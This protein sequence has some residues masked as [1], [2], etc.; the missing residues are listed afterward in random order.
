M[1]TRV[2]EQPAYK[3]HVP[4][5]ANDHYFLLLLLFSLAGICFRVFFS[6]PHLPGPGIRNAK[7]LRRIRV[8]NFY[9]FFIINVVFTSTPPSPI[10]AMY[11]PISRTPHPRTLL[12]FR[13]H[14]TST[15]PST[16]LGSKRPFSLQ[17]CVPPPVLHFPTALPTAC[18]TSKRGE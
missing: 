9:I 4:P 16:T 7:R 13:R 1:R 5:A 2:G 3:Y 12:S 8:N 18:R 11:P 14:S 6:P 15:T 17:H 10:S